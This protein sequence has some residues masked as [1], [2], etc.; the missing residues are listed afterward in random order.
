M[1]RLSALL[2]LVAACAVVSGR[3]GSGSARNVITTDE[4]RAA[5]FADAFRVVEALRPQW[6][7]PRGATTLTGRETVKVYLDDLLLGGP[8]QLQQ[9]TTRSISSIRYLDGNEATQ[10]WGLDHGH[11]AILVLTRP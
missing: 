9:I 1:R 4:M 2:L 6:L 3:R 7:R 8:D 10:R 5:G 11:G